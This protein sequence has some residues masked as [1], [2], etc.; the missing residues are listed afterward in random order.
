M[1]FQST[2]TEYDGVYAGEAPQLTSPSGKYDNGKSVFKIYSNSN[3]FASATPPS[4]WSV[5]LQLRRRLGLLLRIQQHGADAAPR[6][7]RIWKIHQRGRQLCRPPIL[8]NSGATVYGGM[9][10]SES[11]TISIVYTNNIGASL[12]SYNTNNNI[13]TYTAISTSSETGQFNYG[14]AVT[15]NYAFT[16]TLYAGIYGPLNSGATVWFR[17]RTYP[18]SGVMPSVSFGSL[19][20]GSS[21]VILHNHDCPDHNPTTT[22]HDHPATTSTTASTTSTTSV[23]T[24]TIIP[25]SMPDTRLR[26]P[27]QSLTSARQ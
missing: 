12:T 5:D 11:G 23:S 18:P 27:P 2:S 24:T 17:T 15:N 1:S 7:R 25:L 21:F 3:L 6:H 20:G 9:S 19:Q 16:G 10:N 8:E 26:S 4:G 13:Y 22:N 14:S